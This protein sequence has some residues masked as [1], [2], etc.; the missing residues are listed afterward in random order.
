VNA[1]ANN[2]PN[3][4]FFSFFHSAVIFTREIFMYLEVHLAFH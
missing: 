1:T 4:V 3:D 2:R